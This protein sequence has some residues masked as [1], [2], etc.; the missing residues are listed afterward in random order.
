MS[1]KVKLTK[2]YM[3]ISSSNPQID[4]SDTRNESI[5]HAEFKRASLSKKKDILYKILKG[6]KEI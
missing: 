3:N 4:F 6:P 5:F 2:G 1:I